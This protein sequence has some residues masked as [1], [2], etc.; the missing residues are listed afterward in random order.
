MHD[1]V[2]V[3]YVVN[4]RGDT[5]KKRWKMEG[6]VKVK[7]ND[8]M[9]SVAKRE[10]KHRHDAQSRGYPIVISRVTHALRHSSPGLCV[11]MHFFSLK[12][13]LSIVIAV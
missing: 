2:K 9:T 1:P 13:L 5:E 12:G 6:E 3:R 4:H 7:V 8:A 11:E 10:A